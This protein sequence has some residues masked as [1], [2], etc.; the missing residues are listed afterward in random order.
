[1][2]QI[3][4]FAHSEAFSE[5]AEHTTRLEREAGLTRISVQIQ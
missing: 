5:K 1:M 4:A 3:I 2:E